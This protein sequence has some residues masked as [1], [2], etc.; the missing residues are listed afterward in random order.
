MFGTLAKLL[1]IP[2]LFWIYY[3]DII[4]VMICFRFTLQ[5]K[6]YH[7][8]SIVYISLKT[9][10]LNKTLIYFAHLIVETYVEIFHTL[11]IY[12]HFVELI[13]KQNPDII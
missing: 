1:I 9:N 5:P 8:G 13:K 3:L 2:E 7:Y 6:P 12:T 4:Y 11:F 10:Y